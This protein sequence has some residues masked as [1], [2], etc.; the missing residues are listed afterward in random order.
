MDISRQMLR[1]LEH[2][3]ARR[4]VA[5]SFSD[6]CGSVLDTLPEDLMHD[7]IEEMNADLAE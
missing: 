7:C 5:A 3:L 1:A 4:A 2:R 6:Y